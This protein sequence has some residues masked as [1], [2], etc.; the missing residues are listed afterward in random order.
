VPEARFSAG[1]RLRAAQLQAFVGALHRAAEGELG[2][3]EPP[4][5]VVLTA[6]DWRALLSAPYG[7]PLTRRTTDGVSV[8]VPADY[9]NRLL[10]RWDAVLLRAA[11]SGQQAPTGVR[12]FMDA[13]VGLEW[14]HAAL[15]A[16]DL[17]SRAP[18]LNEVLA[19]ALWYLAL[20]AAGQ[21]GQ[22]RI[23]A[24]W[25][26]VQ[27]AGALPKGGPTAF[28]YPRGRASFDELVW[29][30]GQLAEVGGALSGCGWEGLRALRGVVAGGA[31]EAV[32]RVA[33]AQP[34]LP[35]W[36]RDAAL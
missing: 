35:G 13:L 7:W 4:G 21:G 6:R 28:V 18:W 20:E 10:R 25:A 12:A 26:G 14:A 9:P 19:V 31:R 24:A 11:Q 27:R 1:Q 8:V 34:R 15:Y 36:L 32:A 22:R 16:A 5:V 33:A 30:Q 23:A 29:H 2:P 17:R 3:L